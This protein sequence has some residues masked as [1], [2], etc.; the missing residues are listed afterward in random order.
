MKNILLFT[1]LSISFLSTGQVNPDGTVKTP[2]EVSTKTPKQQSQTQRN[3]SSSIGVGIDLGG[4]IRSIKRNKNCNQVEIVFPSNKSKFTAD[5]TIPP[6]FRWNS[7]KPDLVVG[8]KFELVQIIDKEKIILYQEETAENQFTWPKDI[9]WQGEQTGKIRYEF[10]VMALVSNS[11]KCGNDVAGIEFTVTT[12]SPVLAST[13]KESETKKTSGYEAEYS[14]F[15]DRVNQ[16]NQNGI[17][18]LT[19]RNGMSYQIDQLPDF[20]WKTSHMIEGANYKIEVFEVLPDNRLGIIHTEEKI[21]DNRLSVTKVAIFKAARAV[22]GGN[23]M[24]KVTET[25]TGLSSGPS[26]FSVSACDIDLQLSNETIECLGYEGENRKYKICFSSTYQSSVGDLT[27]NH[28]GSGLFV[29]DQSNNPLTPTLVGQ[30]TNLQTQTG[31]SLS[32]VNYCFEVLVPVGVTGIGF[33]LQGDDLDPTPVICQPGATLNSD[34]LPDC[35]CDQCDAVNTD[36]SNFTPT[37]QANSINLN[38]SITANVPIYGIEVQVVSY[39][40]NAQPGACT[41][42]V[43]DLEHS[44]MILLGQS[45]INNDT[46]LQA[47]NLI[48]I[49]NNTNATKAVKYMFNSPMSGSIPIHLDM[50]L[51]LPL[52]GL[53]NGCC[54]IN[55]RVC[56]Q[57][58]I[59]TERGL[60]TSCVF[61]KCIEF[62]N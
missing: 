56:L 5:Q 4:L 42:G 43:T 23:Y 6:T 49:P 40:Y 34:T 30:N 37:T 18:A 53:D 10:Y 14:G 50:G 59:Y 26:Y 17:I 55:Y 47:Y 29:F 36:I 21:T 2:R 44:G 28:A 3:T 16:T 9:A 8:Y 62:T 7:S 22:A 20:T 13:Q 58:K 54:T 15:T 33:G 31:S 11:E 51:P 38:G 39:T 48:G 35:L 61:E 25:N 46:Q 24:W 52:P 57:F 27:F 41:A 32:T 45:S 1:F 60:C 12:E 19:P